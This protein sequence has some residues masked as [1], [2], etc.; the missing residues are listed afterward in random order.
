MMK[1]TLIWAIGKKKMMHIIPIHVQCVR[2]SVEGFIHM[3]NIADLMKTITAGLVPYA[4]I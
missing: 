3:V 2:I 4:D 1:N